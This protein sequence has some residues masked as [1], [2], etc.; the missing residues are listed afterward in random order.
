MNFDTQADRHIENIRDMIK[1]CIRDINSI[2]NGKCVGGD[3][4]SKEFTKKLEIV[5]TKLIEIK[6]LLG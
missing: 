4:I 6:R 1:I 5:F 3:D 2:V